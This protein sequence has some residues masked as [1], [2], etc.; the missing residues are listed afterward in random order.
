MEKQYKVYI[1]CS[2]SFAPFGEFVNEPRSRPSSWAALITSSSGRQHPLTR[3]AFP[4]DNLGSLGAVRKQHPTER[5][6]KLPFFSARKEKEQ[7]PKLTIEKGRA[8]Y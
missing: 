7:K 3:C 6:T 4:G 2:L 8:D 5:K 1:V